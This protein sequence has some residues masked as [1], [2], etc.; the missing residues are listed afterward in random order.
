VTVIIPTHN[1]SGLMQTTLRTVLRQREVDLR[2]IVVDDGSSDDT[3]EVLGAIRDPRVRWHRNERPS[4][5]S[6]ARNTGLAMVDTR[7]VAF[8]DDDDLWAPDKLASQMQ[9]LRSNPAAQWSCVGSVQVDDDLRIFRHEPPPEVDDL[10]DQLLKNNCIPGG[11]SG[12]LA[13]TRLVRGVG[14]FDPEFSNL[15][16]WDLWVRLAFAAPAT[17]IARPLMAYR[18]HARGMA[19]GVRRTEM[20]LGAM[21]EKYAEERTHRGVTIHWSTWWRYLARLHL[22]RGDVRAA[23]SN[24]FRAARTGN[25]TRY[26][27]GA[28]CLFVPNM[29]T[30]ADRRGRLR[31]PRT[32]A[33]EANA[34]LELE[35]SEVPASLSARRLAEVA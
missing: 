35:R 10:D 7:W 26:V 9:S 21:V 24:Y 6:N 18:V 8:T 31:V 2:V 14:G 34:W 12:V 22:R 15:A 16:D 19:H 33:R 13:S 32:W 23:A 1:R 17:S 11:G 4:G 29:S 25:Y 30:W 20:E 3:P 28:M 27:V 5:V